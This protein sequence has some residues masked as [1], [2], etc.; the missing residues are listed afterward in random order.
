MPR[1]VEENLSGPVAVA[2]LAA[3][4]HV[5]EFHFSRLFR[6]ATGTSPHRYLVQRRVERA[7][8]LPVGTDLPVA[9]VAARCGFA[10]AGHLT[11]HARRLLGAPPAA[12]RTAA[13]GR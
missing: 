4:A 5:S 2:D 8:D 10:D 12:V 13:R 7:R 3:R 11:R 1:H 6:A 9:Q